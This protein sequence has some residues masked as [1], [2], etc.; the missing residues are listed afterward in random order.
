MSGKLR[1]QY[2]PF[3]W[4]VIIGLSGDTVPDDDPLLQASLLLSKAQAELNRPNTAPENRHRTEE[5]IDRLATLCFQAGA[6]VS[7]ALGLQINTKL[8]R[9]MRHIRDHIVSF[10]C[11]RRGY[12]DTNETMHK[13]VKTAYKCTNKRNH[14]IAFQLMKSTVPLRTAE[15]ETDISLPRV[16]S[17]VR[18]LLTG[19]SVD[20]PAQVTEV[21]SSETGNNGDGVQLNQTEV[22]NERNEQKAI[23]QRLS[24]EDAERA[25]EDYGHPSTNKPYWTRVKE[26]V[27]K[28]HFE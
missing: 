23:I 28:G 5:N 24:V 19:N 16:Q 6:A 10:G 26:A 9:V 8:H 1:R 13:E 11:I 3:L 21:A 27:F 4:V 18:T 2:L 25:L 15:H 7:K 17:T 12:T 20:C 14:E 22:Q